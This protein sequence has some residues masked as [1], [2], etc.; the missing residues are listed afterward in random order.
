MS[1]TESHI[2]DLEVLASELYQNEQKNKFLAMIDL[3]K[4][5]VESRV[6]KEEYKILKKIV[7]GCYFLDKIKK[8]T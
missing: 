7:E 4:I 8:E 5:P 6:N 1:A 2:R 3:L